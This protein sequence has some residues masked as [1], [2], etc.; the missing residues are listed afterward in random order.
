MRNYL[1]CFSQVDGRVTPPAPRPPLDEPQILDFIL[2]PGE[3]LF[4]PI[5]CLHFVEG[6]DISVTVSFTNFVFDNDFSSFYTTYGSG[7]TGRKSQTPIVWRGNE[8][9]PDL[10]KSV[11]TGASCTLCAPVYVPQL[12]GPP[13]RRQAVRAPQ[14]PRAAKHDHR[15]EVLLESGCGWLTE[16]WHRFDIGFVE[17]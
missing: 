16:P 7:L 17:R 15:P 3:I 6:V 11:P 14:V 2:N 4:L 12:P 13:G 8:A 10:L 1:H 5:G 9:E